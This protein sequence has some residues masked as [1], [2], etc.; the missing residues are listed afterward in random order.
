M[1]L[2][3][4]VEISYR[5]S[6]LTDKVWVESE[7]FLNTTSSCFSDFGF[8][9]MFYKRLPSWKCL[10]RL[11]NSLC[12]VFQRVLNPW[13]NYQILATLR[14]VCAICKV[15]NNLVSNLSECFRYPLGQKTWMT[16]CYVMHSACNRQFINHPFSSP[17]LVFT[18]TECAI[19]TSIFQ[20]KYWFLTPW[21]PNRYSPTYQS[22]YSFTDTQC[23]IEMSIFQ[24]KYCFWLHETQISIHQHARKSVSAKHW[25]LKMSGL[26][27]FKSSHLFN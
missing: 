23:A 20:S 12:H 11:S 15:A 26:W 7:L 19:E 1:G 5:T 9:M 2:A 21:D 17:E 16:R 14:E 6:K 27:K 22:W 4:E 3:Q 8:C 25:F 10:Q 18:N 13:E 24:S